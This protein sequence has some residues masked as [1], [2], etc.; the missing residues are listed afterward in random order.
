MIGNVA[1]KFLLGPIIDRFGVFMGFY[2]ALC[3]TLLG[4]VVF[5]VM[6]GS[7]Y[8]IMFAGLVYGFSFSLGS[9]GTSTITRYLYGNEQYTRAFSYVSMITYFAAGGAIPIIGYIYDYTHSYMPAF[10]IWVVLVVLSIGIVI[11]IERY[12]KKK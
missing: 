11:W 8:G 2:V 1:S 5:I 7:V 6:P 4:L 9:L 12:T 10:Y 3:C